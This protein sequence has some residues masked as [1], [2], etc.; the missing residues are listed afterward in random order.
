MAD[1]VNIKTGV[2][3]SGVKTG[4]A[5]IR[6]QFAGLKSFAAGKLGGA[7]GAIGLT[8]AIG[9]GLRSIVGEADHLQDL[10]DKLGVSA[11]ALQ[12]FGNVAKKN[13]G[14]LDDVSSA[15]GKLLV[16]QAKVKKGTRG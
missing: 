13:G 5:Q 4:L 11:E 15:L 6:S 12:M 2:D 8:T 9:A 3:S 16:A 14:N 1:Q 7:I 10:N